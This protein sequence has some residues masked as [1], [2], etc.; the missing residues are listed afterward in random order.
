MYVGRVVP[1]RTDDKQHPILKLS[2]AD[3]FVLAYYAGGEP[4]PKSL[5]EIALPT[6]Q[7]TDASLLERRRNIVK[8]LQENLLQVEERMADFFD[9]AAI[10]LDLQRMKASLLKRIADA[11]KQQ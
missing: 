10:P 6:A 9:E 7:P 5:P 8:K 11:E 1:N 4:L 3:N 2:Q